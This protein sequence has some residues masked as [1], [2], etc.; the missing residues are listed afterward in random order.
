M[1]VCQGKIDNN[2]VCERCGTK[3]QTSSCYC[4]RL[5]DYESFVPYQICPKC[6]GQGI[7]SKPPWIAEDVN[8][9]TSDSAAYQCDLCGGTKVIPMYKLSETET[10]ALKHLT[11]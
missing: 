10:N 2:G 7:V 3:T 11:H 5:I 6:N 8:Q 9:W 1:K 4:A